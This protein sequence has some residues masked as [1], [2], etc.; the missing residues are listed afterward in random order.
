M[1]NCLLY[2]GRFTI[3]SALHLRGV[4]IDIKANLT[5]NHYIVTKRSQS[6]PGNFLA[7][8]R[9]IDFC[10]IKKTYSLLVCI[11]DKL[12]GILSRWGIAICPGDIHTTKAQFSYLKRSKSAFT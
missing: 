10:R 6:F 11:S 2:M 7:D 12:N 4:E 1:I 3:Q 5:C 8:M 9:T